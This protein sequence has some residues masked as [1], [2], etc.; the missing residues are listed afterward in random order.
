MLTPVQR[1][2]LQ[3]RRQALGIQVSAPVLF[4]SGMRQSRNFPANYLPFRASSHF[5]YFAG[6]PLTDAVIHLQQGQLKLFWDAPTPEDALWHG[7]SLSRDQVAEIIGAIA[8]YPLGELSKYTEAA[9]TIPVQDVVVRQKQAQ[10][11]GRSVGEARL[12]QPQD[13]PLLEAI[14]DLRL[15][16]D[17]G[18]IEQIQQAVAVTVAAH[19]AGMRATGQATTEAQIR[20]AIEAEM[21][22]AQMGPAYGSIVTTCGEV[23]HQ[24]QSPNNLASGALLLVDAGAETALGWASDVTRTWPVSGHWSSTQRDIY[25][26]VLAAHDACIAKAAT[27]VEYRDLHWLAATTLTEGLLNLGLLKGTVEGLL[28]QDVHAVFFPHGVGH[29]L[30]L[31]VHDMEDLGDRAGYAP[32]RQRSDRFGLGF[33]RLDR[34][35]QP[36]MCVTIEPGFY[37]VPALLE[38]AQQND[39]WRNGINWERLQQFQDVRGIRIEDDVLITE[40]GCQVLTAALPTQADAIVEKLNH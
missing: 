12:S 10:L 26:V 8:A 37:Q 20:A 28:E 7:P 16:Q 27:N 19:R 1:N 21:I 31:D 13:M 2:S 30:G 6:I 14:I 5:L 35:L 11:L 18:A 17:A 40:T 3:V 39:R 4:W 23:L 29:L 24:E 22:A 15:Q 36:G 33:L 38:K 32:G 25:D 9:L 34:P